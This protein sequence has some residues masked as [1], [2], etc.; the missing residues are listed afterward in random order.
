[1]AFSSWITWLVTQYL[2]SLKV[3][4][5]RHKHGTTTMER[6]PIKSPSL[7]PSVSVYG[8]HMVFQVTQTLN[9]CA[10]VKQNGWISPP[11]GYYFD[12]FLIKKMLWFGFL[13]WRTRVSASKMTKDILKGACHSSAFKPTFV[14]PLQPSFFWTSAAPQL[15]SSA[16]VF[17]EVFYYRLP[18]QS[19]N[20]FHPSLSININS[21]IFFFPP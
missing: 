2:Y 15:V 10:C 8:K 7:F 18:C 16:C 5:Q 17:W 20:S 11:D 6:S 3:N 13:F 14:F 9:C 19:T 12:N 4:A 1:M 21:F